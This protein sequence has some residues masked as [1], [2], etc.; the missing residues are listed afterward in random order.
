M[1][2]AIVAACAASGIAMLYF[3]G[4]T[5]RPQ[6]PACTTLHGQYI[7]QLYVGPKYVDMEEQFIGRAKQA[8][9]DK[10]Y[11]IEQLVPANMHHRSDTLDLSAVG[12]D[13]Q[14][15][16]WMSHFL[17]AWNGRVTN[18]E[19]LKCLTS[20]N[21]DHSD[22]VTAAQAL[23]GHGQTLRQVDTTTASV[24]QEAVK[25]LHDKLAHAA[26]LADLTY[27]VTYEGLTTGLKSQLDHQERIK[28]VVE[29]DS[30][31][32]YGKLTLKNGSTRDATFAEFLLGRSWA[33]IETSQH[34]HAVLIGTKVDMP[35]R[36][37]DEEPV[38]HNSAKAPS[39]LNDAGLEFNIAVRGSYPPTKMNMAMLNDWLGGNL[40]MCPHT[41]PAGGILGNTEAIQCQGSWNGW[42][43]STIKCMKSVSLEIGQGFQTD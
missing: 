21:Q 17:A 8:D 15:K 14:P 20:L 16:W 12:D 32:D 11:H 23:L 1:L 38:L 36:W 25:H 24:V 34:R 33:C 3:T 37:V 5:F 35:H 30:D 27:Q 6:G 10:P 39:E 26:A 43:C 19:L 22:L 4:L 2:P 9:L 7:P 29:G 28:S 40:R 13:A 31:T 41:E 42:E 18:A